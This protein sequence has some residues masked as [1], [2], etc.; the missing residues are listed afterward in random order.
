MVYRVGVRGH[1][2]FLTGEIAI[3]SVFKQKLK[4]IL[5]EHETDRGYV[6]VEVYTGM[7]LGFEET[8]CFGCLELGVPYVGVLS[9]DGREKDWSM[10][11]AIRNNVLLSKAAR[12]EVIIPGSYRSWKLYEKDQWLVEMSQEMIVYW[13]GDSRGEIGTCIDMVKAKN[14]PF[15]NTFIARPRQS[16]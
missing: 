2:K 14:I 10:T 12:V 3:R 6:D 16:T 9:C 13:D 8:V 5:Q 15:F 7:D 1:E 11:T 4:E